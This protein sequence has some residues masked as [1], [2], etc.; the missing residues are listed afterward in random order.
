M[1]DAS[2]P[3]VHW[4]AIAVMA[5]IVGTVA[6]LALSDD[7]SQANVEHFFRLLYECING[8]CY[9]SMAGVSAWLAHL[10]LW[11]IWVGYALSVIG[12]FVIVYAMMRL[13]ELRSREK[14]FYGTVIA[15]ATV[16]S[17]NNPRWQNIESLM[18]SERAGDW[19]EAIMEADIILD[20]MLT[21]QGYKG[22][23]VGE[24]LKLVEPSDFDSLQD[25]W[26]AHKVRNQVAHQGSAFN[27]SETLARRTIAQYEKVFREF[28]MI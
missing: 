27:F 18:E 12:L 15:S 4:L 20:D 6:V 17:G 9:G 8:S 23:G 2:A 26:E 13:F 28:E 21:R 3:Q 16:G 1:K 7:G 14:E 24:K 5:I 19:R 10:W 22:D 11:I 25:A